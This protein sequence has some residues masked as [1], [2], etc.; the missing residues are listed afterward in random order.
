VTAAVGVCARCGC[1]ESNACVDDLG[2]ACWWVQP[3]LCSSCLTAP[4]QREQL[5]ASALVFGYRLAAEGIP[6]GVLLEFERAHPGESGK[7]QEAVRK[8][9]GLPFARW[10]QLLRRA[11]ASREALEHDPVLAR[12]LRERMEVRAR[13]RAALLRRTTT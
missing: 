3:G 12:H 1:T 4:P 10:M 5:Q 13:R 6:V 7:K 8:E 11:L 2:R 9:F